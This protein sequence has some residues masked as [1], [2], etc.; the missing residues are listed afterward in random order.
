MSCM[1]L[2]DQAILTVIEPMMDDVMSGV[3]NRDYAH[4]CAHFSV[5]LKSSITSDTFLAQC[6]RWEK[7]WGRPS[8]REKV[9]IFRKEKSFT[10]LWHQQFDKTEDQVLAVTTVAIKGGRYFVDGFFLE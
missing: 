9:T 2:D 3:A 8:Q 10:V 7:L 1:E 5:D 4:H 6:D